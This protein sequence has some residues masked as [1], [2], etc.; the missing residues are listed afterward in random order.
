V[1]DAAWAPLLNAP[2][3][4]EYPSGHLTYAGAAKDVLTKFV[5]PNAPQSFTATSPNAPGVVYTYGPNAWTKL[6]EDN[7][8]GRVWSGI[9][10]RFSDKIGA[11]LGKKV[12]NYDLNKIED[13]F[14]GL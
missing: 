10:F 5:G 12:A 2:Q 11:D 14:L 4:P 8:N 3:H 1:G 9:H 6:V 13:D 7:D